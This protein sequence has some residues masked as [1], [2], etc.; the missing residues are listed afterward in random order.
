MLFISHWELNNDFE[1]S[2]LAGIAQKLIEKRLYPVPGVEQIGWYLSA[3]DY[4]GI[5]IYKA[6]SEE[7]LVK[8]TNMWRMVKPGIFK[9]IKVSPAMDTVDLIPA[10]M[11]LKTEL[12]RS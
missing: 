9:S 6:D 1:P 12:D 2:E 4:W 5:S 11:E 10:L 3:S 8:N 7:A